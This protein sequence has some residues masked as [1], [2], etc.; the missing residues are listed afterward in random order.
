MMVAVRSQSRSCVAKA[1]AAVL[2]E[3]ILVKIQSGTHISSH[4]AR[5]QLKIP[6]PEL[7]LRFLH[8]VKL[9]VKT[10]VGPA[11]F[12]AKLQV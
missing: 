4:L 1:V 5:F 3:A 6:S 9:R 7:H 10:I 11:E 12:L 8:T 2:V